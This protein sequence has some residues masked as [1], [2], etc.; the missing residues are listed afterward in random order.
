MD[1]I[2]PM[3]LELFRTEL[4]NHS[5]LLEAG[6]VGVETDQAPERI[7]PLMRAAHSIKGA[8]RI[9]GLPAAVTLAHAMED[10]L[11]AAQHGKLSLLSGHVDC[12]L[13]ETTFF[14][15]CRA[16]KPPIFPNNCRIS[17]NR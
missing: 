5:R 16:P 6:L 13:R 4:E 7:E 1:Q 17:S 11:S 8:A 3:M 12:S 2:D 14:R 15:T 9:V 10:I